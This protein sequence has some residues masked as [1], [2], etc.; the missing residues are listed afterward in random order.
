MLAEIQS[1]GGFMSRSMQFAIL[2]A[3]TVVLLG[4]ASSSAFAA[5][6]GENNSPVARN[7]FY[8]D[9][10]TMLIKGSISVNYEREWGNIGVRFGIGSAAAFETANGSGVMVMANYFPA[11]DHSF[12]IGAGLSLMQMSRARPSGP[13]GTKV[14]P[15]FTMCYR[16]Q[17]PDGGLFFRAGFSYVYYEGTQ[18][19][20]S[21][22]IAF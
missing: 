18:F 6:P 17:P 16:I 7:V 22:G 10:S 15:A 1:R 14:Y 19:T 13:D 8:I 20:V 4:I 11:G 3:Y 21:I 12:D 5:S 9:L 2:S